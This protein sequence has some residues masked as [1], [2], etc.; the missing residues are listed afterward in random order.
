MALDIK[1]IADKINK[2]VPLKDVKLRRENFLEASVLSKLVDDNNSLKKTNKQKDKYKDLDINRLVSMVKESSDR[3]KA[4]EDIYLLFPDIALVV[5]TMVSVILSPKDMVTTQYNIFGNKKISNY[6]S[7]VVGAIIEIIKQELESYYKFKEELPNI[8]EESLFKK[9]SYFKVLLPESKVDYLIN[10]NK[11]ITVEDLS[12]IIDK[13]TNKFKNI[14]F[15]GPKDLKEETKPNSYN[16]A[17][18][19]LFVTKETSSI[20][21]TEENI[22]FGTSVSKISIIDN[23]NILRMPKVI[24]QVTKQKSKNII[25]NTLNTEDYKH[26]NLQDNQI[27][28]K[29][30]RDNVPIEII[31]SGKDVRESIGRPLLLNIPTESVIPLHVPGEPNNHIAYLIMLD[32]EGNPISY[33]NNTTSPTFAS[34]NSQ[35]DNE[36]VSN[37][38]LEKARNNLYTYSKDEEVVQG[39][40]SIYADYIETELVER[41]KN[42]NFNRS[43]AISKRNDIFRIMLSRTLA[44]QETKVLFLPADLAT[45]FAYDYYENGV[46]KSLFDNIRVLLSMRGILLFAK[47]NALSKNSIAIT[48]VNMT[49][50]EDDPDPVKTIEEAMHE[51]IRMRQQFLPI[52]V[53]SPIDLAEWVQRAGLEFTFEGHPDLPN[54]KFDFETNKMNFEV[55]DSDLEEELRKQT[56]MSL[57]LSPETIDATMSP[58]FATTVVEN[59]ILLSKRV[60]IIQNTFEKQF[61]KHIKTICEYDVYIKNKIINII[62]ENENDFKELFKKDNK[63]NNTDNIELNYDEIYNEIINNINFEF[64]KPDSI[65][66]ENQK[67]AFDKYKESLEVVVDLYVSAET[68]NKLA[69]EDLTDDVND[70]KEMLKSYFLRK[71]ITEKGFISELGA[72]LVDTENNDSIVDNILKHNETMSSFILHLMDKSKELKKVITAD[73]GNIQAYSQTEKDDKPEEEVDDTNTTND[74]NF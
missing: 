55:P 72:A 21:N 71:Y 7:N 35:K 66:L 46:G 18:E 45:Y 51:V 58:E 54:T 30:T 4:N 14:G 32:Q 34:N 64:V 47:I 28:R 2:R 39:L 33:I 50:D 74:F 13:A 49:L 3:I 1:Q 36:G 37:F 27:Y 29:M 20:S 5:Q 11:N 59:N 68:L 69:V 67:E 70:F 38:L 61:N 48:K 25:L 44:N 15:I 12:N 42:G 65:T 26:I 17:F 41:L 53:S 40:T 22:E 63:H 52:G 19:S 16:T 10:K 6:P 8:I 23:Y 24:E 9:G 73:K 43:F 31:K 56:I 57:G 62:K 60:T